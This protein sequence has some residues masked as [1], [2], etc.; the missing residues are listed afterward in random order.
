MLEMEIEVETGKRGDLGPCRNRSQPPLFRPHR[1][2]L[3]FGEGTSTTWY[4]QARTI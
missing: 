1:D 4:T 3:V 2:I